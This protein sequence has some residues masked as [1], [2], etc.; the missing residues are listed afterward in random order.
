M[1]I[2]KLFGWVLWKVKL[3]T[4]VLDDIEVGEGIILKKDG[5]F[6]IDYKPTEWHYELG[7]E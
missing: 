3:A 1:K 7:L 4:R 6:S 5:S 2:C